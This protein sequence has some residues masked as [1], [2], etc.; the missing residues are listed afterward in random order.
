MQR[1]AGKLAVVTGASSGIGAAIV[2]D[3]AKNGVNVVGIARRDNNIK[4]T[5]VYTLNSVYL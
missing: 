5:L 2:R 3:L 1:W 4:V